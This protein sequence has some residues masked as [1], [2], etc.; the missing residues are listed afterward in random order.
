[1][2]QPAARKIALK[3]I[4]IACIGG[5]VAAVI[6][7]NTL[8][9]WGISLSALHLTGGIILL[10]VAL[11]NVLAL[12]EKPSNTKMPYPNLAFSPLAFPT[13]LTPYG[14]A[15]YIL[16]LAMT[17]D[18]Y[19]EAL[20]SA[21]FLAMMAINLVVMWFSRAIIRRGGGVL[22]ILGAVLGVLQV[23]LAIQMILTELRLM[24]ILPG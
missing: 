8:V 14:L 2:A 7:Q 1:M 18:P 13:I 20:I 3:A 19:R 23:A 5:V 10:L 24:R 17:H 22:A 11:K 4:G 21:L 6:G 16:L 15:V 9:A 12:Y